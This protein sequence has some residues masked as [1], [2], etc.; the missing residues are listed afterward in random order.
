MFLQLF[1]KINRIQDAIRF[2]KTTSNH[3]IINTSTQTRAGEKYIPRETLQ[4][5]LQIEYTQ[6]SEENS[7]VK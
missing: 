7:S 6:N 3:M 4:Y 5:Q 2:H 1:Y